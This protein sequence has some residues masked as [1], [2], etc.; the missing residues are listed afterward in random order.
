MSETGE[1]LTSGL[2]W[3]LVFL[4]SLTLHEA[5]HAWVAHRLGDSTAYDGGQVTLDPQPHLRREPV[6][7]IL[8]PLVS[9]AMVGWM[10]G[11]ASAP[12]DPLWAQRY[13]RR[14]GWMALAGPMANLA[15][16]AL[17]FGS[18]RIGAGA[19]WLEAPESVN[20]SRI[21]Q[22]SGGGAAAGVG[23]VLSVMFTLN[24]LLFIFNLIPVPPLDGSAV[25]ALV[26][27]ADLVR[28]Y[29]EAMATPASALIGLVAA[30]YLIGPVFRPVYGFMLDLLYPGIDYH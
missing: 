25:L 17:A 23:V 3:Y 8:V 29:R 13:P 7:T 9:Y 11:W 4:L 24:L 26:L 12:Y 21:T 18:I 14:A 30:W 5:A 16:F 20:F 28:R 6:G 19:G 22:A 10:I 27:P 1:L 2:A 15:L